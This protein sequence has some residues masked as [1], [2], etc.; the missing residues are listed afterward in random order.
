MRRIATEAMQ[1][2]E[3][4]AA[5]C[6]YEAEHGL[7]VDEAVYHLDAYEHGGEA[8]LQA[9]RSPDII[10]LE[11]ARRA[12]RTAAEMLDARFQGRPSC[13]VTDEGT[14]IGVYGIRQGKS[15]EE[16]LFAICQLRLTVTSKQ[17]H[18]C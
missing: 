8:G 6:A 7:T 14:A 10:P 5:L 2:G 18:L 3:D 13:R 11:V 12:V 4:D 9:I 17:W 16:Y 1:L 15:G